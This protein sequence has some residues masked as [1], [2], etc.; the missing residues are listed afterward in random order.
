MD[1]TLHLGAHRTGTTTL[2]RYLEKNR[3][4]LKEIGTE[5]WGPKQTRSGL[6]TGLEKKLDGLTELE[7]FRGE[8]ACDLIRLELDRLEMKGAKSLIVSEENMIGSMWGNL[9]NGRLYPEAQGRLQRFFNGF[10]GRCERVAISIRSYEEYWAS[11]LTFLIERGRMIPTKQKIDSL[12]TQPRRWRD[13]ITEVA[14]VFPSA[15]LVV[16]PFE[17]MTGQVNEQLALLNGGMTPEQM[18]GQ[19]NWHNASV[20]AAKIRQMLRD[21]GHLTLA[22]SVPDDSLRWQP[23]GTQQIATFQAQYD[24]DIAWLRSGA[25]GIARFEDNSE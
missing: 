16:W 13:L 7:I 12:V 8:R 24:E 21:G 10:G 1:V 20:G 25:D 4:N 19:N 14:G 23:Y 22:A 3:D 15:E 11:A 2:Q 18:C 6:F 9:S 5:F 17:A